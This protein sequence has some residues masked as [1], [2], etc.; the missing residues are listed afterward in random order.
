MRRID[1]NPDKIELLPVHSWDVDDGNARVVRPELNIDLIFYDD[2]IGQPTTMDEMRKFFEKGERLVFTDN[3]FVQSTEPASLGATTATNN[4][5]L[6][7][8]HR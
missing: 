7:L 6:G 3:T 2:P 4:V 8:D 1:L 5:L